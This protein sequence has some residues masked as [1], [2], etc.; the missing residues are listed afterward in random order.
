MSRK[1]W[2]AR[3]H[4]WGSD[5]IR[6]AF[7]A[8][9]SWRD[10]YIC[11]TLATDWDSMLNWLRDAYTSQ[12]AFTFDNERSPLPVDFASI[13][14]LRETGSASLDVD[15]QGLHLKCHFFGEQEIEFD[16]DPSEMN[17]MRWIALK[18]FMRQM[19]RLLIRSV[20]LT[21]ENYQR[22][23]LILYFHDIDRFLHVSHE[24][25]DKYPDV[26]RDRA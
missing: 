9:G 1:R 3:P 11:N 25:T 8:D 6:D 7:V 15:L 13:Q 2:R 18:K 16:L 4:E 17:E 20:L 26:N 5:F 14:K 21:P 22:Y 23:P 24:D 10:I 12:I 19:G